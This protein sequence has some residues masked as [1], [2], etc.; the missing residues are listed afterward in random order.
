MGMNIT[1]ILYSRDPT[2]AGV[3]TVKENTLGTTKNV[4]IMRRD[5]F[6]EIPEN[7]QKID[8]CKNADV[9][10]A[11]ERRTWQ[12][13]DVPA[14]ELRGFVSLGSA[15]SV[16]WRALVRTQPAI[17]RLSAEATTGEPPGSEAALGDPVGGRACVRPGT[18]ICGGAVCTGAFPGKTLGRDASRTFRGGDYSFGGESETAVAGNVGEPWEAEF[19][20]RGGSASP[21]SRA[22]QAQE[23]P[24]ARR[25]RPESPASRRSSSLL[26]PGGPMQALWALWAREALR[27]FGVG[28]RLP[29]GMGLVKP[30]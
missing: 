3:P 1:T 24:Q 15:R 20:G 21:R 19:A 11:T 10:N 18:L 8:G 7:I 27:Q 12:K 4:K 30:H 17:V 6:R 14:G 29:L 5:V 13:S 22:R 28:Q 23:A 16:L 2:N 25:A 26:G 9:Q